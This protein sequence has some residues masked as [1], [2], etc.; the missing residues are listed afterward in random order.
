[1]RKYLF[2]FVML[3]C[4][5]MTGCQYVRHHHNAGT[6]VELLGHALY[7]SDLAE[8]TRN[9]TSAEDS[10]RIADQY[11]QQ[12]AIDLLVYEKAKMLKSEEIEKLVED[13]RRALYIHSYEQHRVEKRMPRDISAEQIQTFY[14]EHQ[15][16][17]TLKENIVRGIL[18]VVPSDAPDIDK[19]RK[20]MNS[21]DEEKYDHI[22]KYA[23]TYATGYELFTE[24]WKT[25]NQ[26]LLR[27]PSANWIDQLK[28]QNTPAQLIEKDSISTYILQV[29]EK[30]MVGE[31]APIEWAKPEIEKIILRDR[32]IQFIQDD[33]R[34]LYED[35]KRFGMINFY[36]DNDS[37]NDNDNQ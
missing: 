22:E 3:F 10:A 1:M 16:N 15:S 17:F 21:K 35:A 30:H 4:I 11:I 13:Y 6:V 29:T 2:T 14:D 12:W 28:K 19:L 7:E 31:I 37:E 26:I 5:L 24:D 8:I 32:Q 25:T 9:A 20:W 34:Q 23:Y 18:V 27:M 33:H 36:N